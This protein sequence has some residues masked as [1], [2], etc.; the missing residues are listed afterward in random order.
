M[1]GDSADWIVNFENVFEERAAEANENASDQADDAGAYAAYETT[2]RGDC[3]QP[4]EQAVAAHRIVHFAV[5]YPHIKKRTE[6]SGAARQHRIHRDAADSQV[7]GCR[8]AQ[9]AAGVESEP[10]ER[11]NEAAD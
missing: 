5:L 8:S 1:D 4:G 9:R 11:K 6:R 7:T 10:T 3:D 2:W